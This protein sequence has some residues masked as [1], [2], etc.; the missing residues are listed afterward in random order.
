MKTKICTKCYREKELNK[1]SLHKGGKYGISSRCKY[2]DKKYRENNREKIK[3]GQSNYYLR[4]KEKINKKN[5][6]YYHENKEKYKN[7]C[8]KRKELLPWQ[9]TLQYIKQ[10]CNNPN[11]KS[12]K[13]YGGRGIKNFLTKD[14]IKYLWFRD[15]AYLME[16]P[17]IDRKDNDGNYIFYNC[18]YIEFVQNINKDKKYF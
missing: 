12:Y 17:S 2:C 18:Q 13:Y 16:K 8:Q 9:K 7:R 14:D 10:R 11:H 5:K 15:K 3:K 1:F 4:N 6:K